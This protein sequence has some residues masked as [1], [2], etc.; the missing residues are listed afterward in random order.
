ME[1]YLKNKTKIKHKRN[2]RKNKRNR[3]IFIKYICTYV[4]Y[5]T[6]QYNTYMYER[7]YI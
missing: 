7:M 1:I 5:N 6:I 4:P 2:E 3:Q